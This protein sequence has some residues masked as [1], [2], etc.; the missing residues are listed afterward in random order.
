[1]FIDHQRRSSLE[2]RY[3]EQEGKDGTF[4]QSFSRESNFSEWLDGMSEKDQELL[5]QHFVLRMTSEEIG[6]ELR[7]PAATVRARLYLA[8]KRLRK[9]QKDNLER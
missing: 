5:H 4:K 8:I 3:L 7:I 6:E 1:M 9:Q 2:A